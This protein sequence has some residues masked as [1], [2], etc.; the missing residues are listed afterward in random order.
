MLQVIKSIIP[1]QKGTFIVGGS[2]RDLL[3]GR[4]PADYDIACTGNPEKFAKKILAQSGGHFVRLGKSDQMIFRV[5]SDGMI[6]D[7]TPLNGASI[8]ED[9]KKRDFTVN[10]V[11]YDLCS[12]KIIDCLGG[13]KDLADK[14]VRMVS[15]KIFDKDPVR[16]IRAYRIA[17]CLNFEIESETAELTAFYSKLLHNIAGERIRAELLTML[18]VSSSYPYLNQMANNGILDAVFPGFG[19]L[20]GCFQ[21]DQHQFDVFEHTMR[22]FGHL[23]TLLNKPEDILPDISFSICRYIENTRPALIKCAILMH[24]IGKPLVKTFDSDGKRRFYGHAKKSAQM[25][26][27][28]GQRLKFSN[29]EQKFIHCIVRH[30][31][32]PLSL[33]TA[34][35]KKQSIEKGIVRFFKKSSDHTPAVLLASLADTKAKQHE[36][37][38]KNNNF[39]TFIHK[40]M[41]EYFM[42]YQDLI[43]KPPLITGHDLIHVFGLTPSPL[44]KKILDLVDDAKLIQAVKN[45]SEAL[46][47]VKDYLLSIRE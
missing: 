15:K 38:S 19:C 10:A 40:L 23:E 46:E 43:D 13:L 47:L 32:I 28:I 39:V 2:V 34:I 45:R 22:A 9:L 21:N 4:V 5:I 1:R 27:T 17:A 8:E 16:L 7:I 42:S 37:T 35:E 26:Q 12:E 36:M 6:F 14:K 18:D 20:K 33:F 41:Y 30:H 24:D 31:M 11:A 29:R 3:L 25:A 44:F